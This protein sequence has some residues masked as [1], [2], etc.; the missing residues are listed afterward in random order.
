MTTKRTTTPEI[1]DRRPESRVGSRT[2][3]YL[4]GFLFVTT[5]CSILYLNQASQADA[6]H[7]EILTRQAE[8]AVLRRENALIREVIARSG[9]LDSIDKWAEELGFVRID[10]PV[11]VDFT[12][13]P[14][15]NEDASSEEGIKADRSAQITDA[16]DT[17]DTRQV[18]VTDPQSKSTDLGEFLQKLVR[19]F[20]L[21]LNR[22]S[23]RTGG[24]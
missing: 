15:S 17:G 8:C 7:Q 21:W 20:E 9:S 1:R 24:R 23:D 3:A 2:L 11:Y 12:Y 22:G 19:Q 18:D 6:L 10:S 14:P 13:A 5:L 16:G 4:A